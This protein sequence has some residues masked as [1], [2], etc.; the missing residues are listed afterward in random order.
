ML[1]LFCDRRRNRIKGFYKRGTAVDAA[2]VPLAD[3]GAEDRAAE[4]K[5]SSER[6][7][8]N[9]IPESIENTGFLSRFV[10][11]FSYGK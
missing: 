5:Q 11:S 1:F 4:G 3:G 9:I 8:R 2:A 6:S 10:V 7:E